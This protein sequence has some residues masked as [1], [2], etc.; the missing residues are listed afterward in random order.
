MKYWI[1]DQQRPAGPFSAQELK[2]VAGF[3]RASLVRPERTLDPEDERWA[4]AG[5]LPQLALLL[6]EVERASAPPCLIQPEP[7][8]RDLPVLGAI[9][10]R[11]EESEEALLALREELSAA[12][13]EVDLLRAEGAQQ[14]EEAARLERRL[15]ET[16]ARLDALAERAE[17]ASAAAAGLAEARDRLE[18]RAA[19]WEKETAACRTEIAGLKE[20][21]A[22]LR[23]ETAALRAERDALAGELA[24]VGAAQARLAESVAAEAARRDAAEAAAWRWG[25]ARLSP[26]RLAGALVFA[27]AIA[28][29]GLLYSILHHHAAPVPPPPPVPAPAP[30]PPPPVPVAAPSPPPA[31]KP[32][33]KKPRP[34]PPTA[35]KLRQEKLKAQVEAEKRLRYTILLRTTGGVASSKKD[36]EKSLER[37]AD[38]EPEKTPVPPEEPRP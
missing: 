34:R 4:R 10:T 36:A 11:Q 22:A 27:I 20:E 7:T 37:M 6:D 21:S 19:V 3:G 28:A 35:A 13:G 14:R 38:K 8:V 24:A 33:A 25:R 16:S 23:T 26:R 31:V 12:R 9:L 30:K 29:G 15:A 2:G 17:A 18:E 32:P 5:E 1:L